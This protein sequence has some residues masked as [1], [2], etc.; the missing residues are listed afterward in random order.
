VL[1]GDTSLGEDKIYM[2]SMAGVKVRFNFPYIKD[3]ANNGDIAINEARLII[4]DYFPDNDDYAA[5]P[6]LV[7]L[8]LNDDGTAGFIP[9][10]FEG[11]GYFGGQYDDETG[12]YFFR[13]SRYIQ[14]L[15]TGDVENYGMELV[16]SGGSLMPNRATLVGSN[17]N[18]PAIDPGKRLK[19]KLIYTDLSN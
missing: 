18:N 1:N 3:W 12:E 2:Q 14:S 9:D 19:L 8:K 6:E 5:P 10:Q 4:N 11:T 13:I 16:V 15:L 17:P 7:V